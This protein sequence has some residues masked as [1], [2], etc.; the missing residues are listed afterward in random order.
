MRGWN[1]QYPFFDKI[2][3]LFISAR[4]LVH[5]AVAYNQLL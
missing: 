2:H 3:K 5:C 4:E 1:L